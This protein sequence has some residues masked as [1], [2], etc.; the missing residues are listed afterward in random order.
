MVYDT[1]PKVFK[2][3]VKVA[4]DLRAK[5]AKLTVAQSTK[6]AFKSQEVVKAKKE[7]DAHKKKKG[8]STK[9]APAR[10]R[11]TTTATKK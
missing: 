2:L 6:M 7:Y 5:N 10:K 9:K 4:K 11:R 1:W 8:G 3:A